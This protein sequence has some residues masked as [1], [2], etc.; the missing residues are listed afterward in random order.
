MDNNGN[1]AHDVKLGAGLKYIHRLYVFKFSQRL[2][3]RPRLLVVT[4][5]SLPVRHQRFGG[6]RCLHLLGPK[7]LTT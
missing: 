1:N 6:T 2:K 5:C 3:F 7:N 4:P